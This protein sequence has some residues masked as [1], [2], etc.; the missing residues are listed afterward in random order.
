MRLS[1]DNESGRICGTPRLTTSGNYTVSATN[2]GGTAYT[3]FTLIVT[4]SGISLTF[5]TSIMELV[6]GSEM[7]PFAGQTSGS[8]PDSVEYCS[9]FAKWI[10]IWRK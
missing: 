3:N 1:F 10:G 5:P 9:R 6:N 2:S 8:A 7:Q 4:G